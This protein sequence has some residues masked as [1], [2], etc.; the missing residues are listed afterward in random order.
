[1]WSI[2]DRDNVV[3]MLSA[4]RPMLSHNWMFCIWLFLTFQIWNLRKKMHVSVRYFSLLATIISFLTDSRPFSLK[5]SQKKQILIMNE[6]RLQEICWTTI[7]I[8]E[9]QSK[10]W[11]WKLYNLLVFDSIWFHKHVLNYDQQKF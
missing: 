10:K 8:S 2:R 6:A 9:H 11:I 1:M 5:F 3:P 7:I 4:K